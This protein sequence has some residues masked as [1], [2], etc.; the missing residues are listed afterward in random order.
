M[1]GNYT[2]G[3]LYIVLSYLGAGHWHHALYVHVSHPYGM[4]YH[5]IPGTP[6]SPSIL[7]D[8]LTDDLSTSRTITAALLVASDV[9]GSDLAHAHSIFVDTPVPSGTTPITSP[10]AQTASTSSEWVVSALTRFRAAVAL[11]EEPIALLME[12]A[13]L[14][15]TFA[16]SNGSREMRESREMWERRKA[17]EM[18]EVKFCGIGGCETCAV[19]R[20][21]GFENG[22]GDFGV[23]KGINRIKHRQMGSVK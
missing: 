13:A 1:N 4:L 16:A 10:V 6:T 19:L 12:E 14:L 7:T 17:G 8:C 9:L 11:I 21:G 2:N 5:P 20:Q 18:W 3:G 22:G 15:A 23:F